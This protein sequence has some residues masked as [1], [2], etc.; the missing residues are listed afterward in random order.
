MESFSGKSDWQKNQET[1]N[2]Q[3]IRIL[4]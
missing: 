2:R 4:Q 3:W 1:E